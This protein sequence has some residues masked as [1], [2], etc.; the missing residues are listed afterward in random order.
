MVVKLDGTK[1]DISRKVTYSGEQKMYGQS[2]VSPDNTLFGSSQL[3]AY[4]RYLKYDD[5]DPYSCY[6]KK[7]S[8]ELKGA[9]NEYRKNAID[10]F[11]AEI[12]PI[13]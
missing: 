6:T 12:S 11:K 8:A 5:K 3:E 1:L 9:F 4:W 13:C 7:E 10:P 2:L